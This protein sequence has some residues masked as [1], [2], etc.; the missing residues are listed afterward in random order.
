M[1]RLLK[2]I[3]FLIIFLN[4]SYHS[5][6][7]QN[8]RKSKSSISIK[9]SNGTKQKKGKGGGKHTS[10]KNRSTKST[11][12]KRNK[13][14]DYKMKDEIIPLQE[15]VKQS[16]LEIPVFKDTTPSKVVTIVSSFKPQLKNLVK[17]NFTNASPIIDTQTA[18]YTYQ[19]PGQNLQFSYRPIALNPLAISISDKTELNGKS[20]VKIGFGNYLYQY[21][22]A[23]F[24]TT[25]PISIHH[26][27][28]LNE[29]SEGIHHLQKYRNLKFDYQG[30]HSIS[31]NNT[32]M[33]DVYASQMQSYRYGL[34]PDTLELPNNNYEQK[35]MNI[36][37]NVALLHKNIFSSIQFKPLF[38]FDHI[39]DIQK[40]SNLYVSISSPLSHTFQSGM[41][42]NFDIQ[43]S[44][45]GFKGAKNS[46]NSLF[47][48][49]PS[50][51]F[52]KWKLKLLFGM[53]PVS[54]S[55]G[56]RLYPNIQ[57][58][59]NLKDSNW[60]FKAGWTTTT[61]NT[62]YSNLLKENPW[63]SSPLSLK[64]ATHEKQYFKL[65]NNVSKN[66][67]YGFGISLNKYV[68]LPLYT[69]EPLAIFDVL[70]GQPSTA[71][72]SNRHL[73]GLRYQT[74]FESLAK[75]IELEANAHYQFSDQFALDNQ[76]IYTQFNFLEDNEKPWGFVPIQLNS[77][78]HW[79]GSKNLLFDGSLRLLS[80]IESPSENANYISNTLKS[81]LI[82]NAGLQY[83]IS[84]PWM[85]W[86][87]AN[88]LLN[89]QYE[90]WGDYPSLGVQINAGVV[91]SFGK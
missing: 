80:G 3:F 78:F 45:S 35:N 64:I 84:K 87:K 56:F 49:D 26:F 29:S 10:S 36:G 67:Q 50:L 37:F 71:P 88:N 21:I 9:K 7:K 23:N 51:S 86:V 13:N 62:L 5:D 27:S 34:V 68:N 65:S 4:T 77:T 53:S 85:V 31:E 72:N 91:Y 74:I 90:R 19:I 6:A 30:N 60:T 89:K 39:S 28:I 22:N 76:F 47:R 41:K 59:Q 54:K 66:L 43:Y 44:Y 16:S 52:D 25:G 58:Q 42:L 83:K 82:L 8:K 17:I 33:T 55:D 14:L 18:L 81:A 2:Y 57:L 46:S 61:T 15:I 69:R 70:P 63:I 73:I 40:S 11:S 48:L 12:K 79:A 32:L 20:N 75:T 24:I 1:P 38:V